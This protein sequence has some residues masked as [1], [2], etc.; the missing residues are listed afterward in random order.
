MKDFRKTRGEVS[1]DPD[2]IRR[3][4]QQLLSEIR[5][6]EKWMHEL[7]ALPHKDAANIELMTTY[8]DMLRSREDMLAILR[9]Q[10][11]Q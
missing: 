2:L 1:V 5:L 3:G 4:E 8:Q 6:I 10:T 7:N 9:E 11:T